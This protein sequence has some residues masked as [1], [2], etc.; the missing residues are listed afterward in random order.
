MADRKWIERIVDT[1]G[2]CCP[3]LSHP[4]SDGMCPGNRKGCTFWIT[5]T[6]TDLNSRDHDA[7]EGCLFAFQYVMQNEARVEGVRTQK[8]LQ[9]A[10][11][12]IASAVRR[13][14]DDRAAGQ[15]VEDAR[16]QPRRIEAVEAE[17]DDLTQ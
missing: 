11:N 14:V 1:A 15:V 3:L 4:Q 13:S 8:T 5:E 7:V 16:L 6:I 2:R 10:A 17:P 12:T 9:H